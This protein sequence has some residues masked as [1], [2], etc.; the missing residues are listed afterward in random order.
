MS[1][2][3]LRSVVAEHHVTIYKPL[4]KNAPPKKSMPEFLAAAARRS[5]RGLGRFSAFGVYETH[6][7]FDKLPSIRRRHTKD[8]GQIRMGVSNSGEVHHAIS[9]MS[10][11]LN[12]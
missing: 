1:A 10:Y 12:S 7:H 4:S 6:L 8:A 2:K 11:S 9:Q 5:F 3:L